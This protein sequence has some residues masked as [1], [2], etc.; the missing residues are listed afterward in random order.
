[1]EEVLYV[2]DMDAAV[3]VAGTVRKAAYGT[4]SPQCVSTIA[5]VTR[6]ALSEQLIEISFTAVLPD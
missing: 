3:A 6:L 1:V 4:D 5:Q 2:L